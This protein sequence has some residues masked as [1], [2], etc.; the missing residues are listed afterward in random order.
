MTY[1][2]LHKFHTSSL[3]SRNAGEVQRSSDGHMEPAAFSGSWA[4][5]RSLPGD[6]TATFE[7]ASADRRRAAGLASDKR[8]T[9]NQLDQRARKNATQR[10]FV[11]RRHFWPTRPSWYQKA[12]LRFSKCHCRAT[13]SP[14]KPLASLMEK[15]QRSD[16]NPQRATLS[17]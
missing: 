16:K 6:Q 15:A 4:L 13:P 5:A 9:E 8:S 7:I 11:T 1:E 17:H 12:T 10:R 3:K 2:G 14:R